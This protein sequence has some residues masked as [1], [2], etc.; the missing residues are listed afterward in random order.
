[1]QNLSLKVQ[2][3][4][5]K[6]LSVCCNVQTLVLLREVLCVQTDGLWDGLQDQETPSRQPFY[7]ENPCVDELKPTCISA[8]LSEIAS[9]STARR[10]ARGKGSAHLCGSGSPLA[11][12][13]RVWAVAVLFV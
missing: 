2:T 8:G 1:M 13:A 6:F 3:V 7:T 5:G 12:S 9:F 4:W 10:R 11:P